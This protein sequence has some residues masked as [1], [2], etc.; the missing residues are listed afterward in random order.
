MIS[1]NRRI[2]HNY[3]IGE[4][5]ECGLQTS[6]DSKADTIPPNE[7]ILNVTS[8][9]NAVQL[10]WEIGTATSWTIWRSEVSGKLG[11]KIN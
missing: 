9:T 10:D 6:L 2:I 4:I 3:T 1:Y 8:L 5:T 7:I 11:D